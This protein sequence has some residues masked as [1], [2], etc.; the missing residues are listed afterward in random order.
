MRISYLE[1][2]MKKLVIIGAGSVVFTKGIINNLLC[3]MP[4]GHQWEI[5]LCDT[6]EISLNNIV[7]LAKK[8]LAIKETTVHLSWSTDR[9]DLLSDADYV[10]STIGVGGRRAWEQDV[11]IPR[12]YGINQPVGDTAMAGG[13]SR[14]MRMVPA[15]IEIV[16]DVHKL[17]PQAY[18][19][20]YSN[21]M[22][23]ICRALR[24]AT[25]H[26]VT[27]LCHGVSSS[28]KYIASILGCSENA[29]ST[30]AAGIN[31]CTFIY[32]IRVNGKN[33][34]PDLH[35]IL[36]RGKEPLKISRE[37][38]CWDFFKKYNAF[39]A[40]GDRHVSEFFTE[41]FP[42]GDYYGRKL[43]FDAFSFEHCILEGGEWT[44]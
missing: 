2:I 43:G 7:K 30:L 29:I 25:A 15:L 24:K 18:F 5:A 12:K 28:E 34:I 27:G 19:F 16:N 20:N 3:S 31:H 23:V 38:F 1:A 40:P 6:N 14:A 11:F 9:C 44:K 36:Q 17:A 21:P 10:I 8:M 32:D 37:P 22:A 35:D 26:E 41:Y 39:P 42:N 13:I 33:V 4:G